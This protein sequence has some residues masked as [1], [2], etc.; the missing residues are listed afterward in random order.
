MIRMILKGVVIGKVPIQYTKLTQGAP[1][2]SYLPLR[3]NP[4]GVIPVIF[5]GSITTAPATILQFLQQIGRA[6]A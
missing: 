3:V 5:A 2:S 1:T 6:H 4:A